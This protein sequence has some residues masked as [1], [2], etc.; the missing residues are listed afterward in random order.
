MK[1]ILPSKFKLGRPVALSGK[2]VRSSHYDKINRKLTVWHRGRGK[3]THIDIPEHVYA[4]LV[5]SSDPDWYYDTYIFDDRKQK[6]PFIKWL[7]IAAIIL[8][9]VA[10]IRLESI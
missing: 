3:V 5:E 8:A 6:S 2:S 10:L 1:F 7:V 4:L 9:I